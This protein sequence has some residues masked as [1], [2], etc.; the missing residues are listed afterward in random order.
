MFPDVQTRFLEMRPQPIHRLGREGAFLFPCGTDGV[1]DLAVAHV[2]AG[3]AAHFQSPARA[4]ALLQVGGPKVGFD[5]LGRFKFHGLG[6]LRGAENRDATDL[7]FPLFNNGGVVDD[8][9]LSQEFVEIHAPAKARLVQPP[10]GG[11]IAVMTCWPQQYPAQAAT[12]HAVKIPLGGFKLL[13]LLHV[14]LGLHF[15]ERFPLGGKPLGGHRALFA[16]LVKRMGGRI[17][18][19][20]HAMALGLIQKHPPQAVDRVSPVARLDLLGQGCDAAGLGQKFDVQRDEDFLRPRNRGTLIRWPLG[21]ALTGTPLGV[22]WPALASGSTEIATWTA[23]TIPRIRTPLRASGRTRRTV[24]PL[25]AGAAR[26]LALRAGATIAGPSIPTWAAIARTTIAGTTVAVKVAPG[27]L[28][29]IICIRVFVGGLFEPVGEKFQVE[30][31]RRVT[32]G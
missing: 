14:I 26:T 3:D 17:G 10:Q 21:A 8:F 25:E 4:D 30:I 29:C 11:L 2:A 24:P 18:G 6:L 7:L 20:P 27:R 16:H 23:A 15:A 5:F 9:D 32:H 31:K 28:A 19:D 1:A 22:P 13:A 12:G